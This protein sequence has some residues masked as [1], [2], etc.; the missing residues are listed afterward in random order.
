MTVGWKKNGPR[1]NF[2]IDYYTFVP[3]T[4]MGL[5]TLRGLCRCPNIFYFFFNSIGKQYS[6]HCP[7]V[8]GQWSVV[9]GVKSILE[10]LDWLSAVNFRRKNFRRKL[11]R[12]KFHVGSRKFRFFFGGNI[13][14]SKRFPEFPASGEN[15]FPVHLFRELKF[16]PEKTLAENWKLLSQLSSY[17]FK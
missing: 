1:G 6:G 2:Y 7:L 4:P 15:L 13:F 14:R 3:M 17:I 12:R 16:P 5:V 11:F 9:S 8:S 10:E